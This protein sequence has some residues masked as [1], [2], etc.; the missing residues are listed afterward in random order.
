[1]GEQGASLRGE[2]WLRSPGGG[3]VGGT[4]VDS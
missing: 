3:Q 4:K 1:M 2:C